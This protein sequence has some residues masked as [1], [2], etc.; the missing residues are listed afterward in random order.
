MSQED[1]DK[2]IGQTRR[3]YR[4]AKNALAAL[5]KDASSL[6][7]RLTKVGHVLVSSPESLI[8]A[9]QSHDGRFRTMIDPVLNVDEFSNMN[10]LVLTNRI[11]DGVVNVEKLR[12]ALIRLEGEDPEGDGPGGVHTKS[13]R[14]HF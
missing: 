10:L 3:E 2:V 9:G 5:R 13:V 8:F 7:N 14:P 12:Q 4:E 11:R 6:G 1:Q